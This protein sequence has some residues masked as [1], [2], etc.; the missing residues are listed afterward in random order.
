MRLTR[1]L[2]IICTALPLLVAVVATDAVE[3]FA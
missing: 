3:V 1:I 2:V